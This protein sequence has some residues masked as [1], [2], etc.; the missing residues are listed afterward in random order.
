MVTIAPAVVA[1]VPQRVRRPAE[2]H[3][4]AH[5]AVPPEILVVAGV[6]IVA[7]D[8]VAPVIDVV[9]VVDYY[10]RVNHHRRIDDHYRRWHGIDHDHAM[11]A[12]SQSKKGENAARQ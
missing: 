3:P 12:A 8:V 9:A 5:S 4:D 10:R 6:V 7:L 1:M 11:G 2:V